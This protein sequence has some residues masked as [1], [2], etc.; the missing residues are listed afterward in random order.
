LNLSILY[1]LCPIVWLTIIIPFIPIYH[2]KK[3]VEF[4]PLLLIKGAIS[5]AP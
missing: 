2:R 4:P 5:V 1:W 3:M